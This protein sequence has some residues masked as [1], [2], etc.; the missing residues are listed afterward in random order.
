[1]ETRSS[2]FGV[3]KLAVLLALVATVAVLLVLFRHELS[4]EAVAEKEQRILDFGRAHP[5]LVV[6]MS[7]AVYVVVTGLSVPGALVLT[8]ANG[9]LLT[10]LYGRLYGF[11]AA[12]V[13]VSFASAIGATI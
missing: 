5:V 9:W 10:Q 2:A 3:R 6:A 1:M 12:I 11:L 7:F 8:L 13:L 4:L